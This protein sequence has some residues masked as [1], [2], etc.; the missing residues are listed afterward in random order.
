[1]S[2]PKAT[3]LIVSE[4]NTIHTNQNAKGRSKHMLKTNTARLCAALLLTAAAST[5][6]AQ[7]T[8]YGIGGS[9][10]TPTTTSLFSFRSNA[11]GVLTTVGNVTGIASGYTL[12]AIDFRPATG[13]LYG[14]AYDGAANAQL[15]T[16]SLTTGVATVQGSVFNVGNATGTA[17]LSIGIGFNPSVD[18]I[19]VVTGTNGNFRI[20]PTTGAI[21]TTNGVD[22]GLAYAAGD[23]RASSNYQITDADYT[24]DARLF[25]VDYTN[26]ALVQQNPPNNG[27]LNSIVQGGVA[28]TLG[29]TPKNGATNVGFDIGRTNIGYLSESVNTDTG[30]QER[31]FNV[32]L[33]TGS[34]TSVGLIGTDT[35]FNTLD[36]AVMVPEP[37]TYALCAFGLV[38]LAYSTRLHRRKLAA[39]RGGR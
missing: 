22:G 6:S 31:L 7:E 33:I 32:D 34:A 8:I 16:L 27:T 5:A 23:L 21:V 10:F 35:N 13:Q 29:F 15:Y 28:T 2:V 14:L 25:D 37:G 1:M 38:A 19:R 20:N 3:P 24:T 4:A 9:G 11:P 12:R 30:V 36:I 26:G 17:S 39:V 18:L